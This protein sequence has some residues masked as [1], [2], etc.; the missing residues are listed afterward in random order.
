LIAYFDF[1]MIGDKTEQELAVNFFW[2]VMIFQPHL[3]EICCRLF[4]FNGAFIK[5]SSFQCH[6]ESVIPT[7][8]GDKN[9]ACKLPELLMQLIVWRLSSFPFCGGV[10]KHRFVLF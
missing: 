8:G 6:E 3:G 4:P 7:R 2:H 9:F 10:Y 5:S 1:E